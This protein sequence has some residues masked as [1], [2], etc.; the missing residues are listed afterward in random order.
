MHISSII[1]PSNPPSIYGAIHK[2]CLQNMLGYWSSLQ[3]THILDQSTVLQA[4][5]FWTDPLSSVQTSF[6]DGPLSRF[7]IHS[8]FITIALLLHLQIVHFFDRIGVWR[9]RWCHCHVS[10]LSPRTL[11][12][13]AQMLR[14]GPLK[15]RWGLGGVRIMILHLSCFEFDSQLVLLMSIALYLK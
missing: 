3:L 12:G 5:C 14:G 1:H 10:S 13:H 8:T 2:G 9:R 6:V 11:G 7:S 4:P 15:S